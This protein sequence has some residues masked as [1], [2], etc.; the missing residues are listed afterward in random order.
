MFFLNFRCFSVDIRRALLENQ[1]GVPDCVFHV[2]SYGMSGASVNHHERI[3][4]V[5]VRATEKLLE[6]CDDVG[7]GFFVHCSSYNAVFCG[8]EV[9]C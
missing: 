8:E 3:E 9:R 5:N 6:L 1:F 7:V 4:Q 2:A